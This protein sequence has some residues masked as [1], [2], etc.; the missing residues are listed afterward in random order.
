MS[1][2]PLALASSGHPAHANP[3]LGPAGDSAWVFSDIPQPILHEGTQSGTRKITPPSLD[4]KGMLDLGFGAG[5][6]PNTQPMG[7]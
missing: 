4:D 3:L 1:A 5:L 6:M 7:L 2:G